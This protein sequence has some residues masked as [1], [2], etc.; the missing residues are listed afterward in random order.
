MCRYTKT[1]LTVIAFAGVLLTGVHVV[2]AQ[3]SEAQEQPSLYDRLGGLMPLSV[4]VNDFMDAVVP[5]VF[6]NQNP[7]IAEARVRVPTPYLKYQ[8]TAMMCEVTGGPCVYNGRNM[9]DAHAH[10][11]ITEPEWDRM[12]TLFKN[13][14]VEHEV[15]EQETA[16]LLSIIDSTKVDIVALSE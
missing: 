1:L 3:S 10:L 9:K 13:T 6:L 4:V 16:E 2:I 15:P 8:V 11:N 7:A 14:L 12:V 5:D